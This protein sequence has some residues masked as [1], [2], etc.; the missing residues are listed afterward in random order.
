MC[1]IFRGVGYIPQN[2]ADLYERCAVM[3]FEEWDHSRGIDSGGPLRADARFA[4]QDIAYWTLTTPSLSSGIPEGLLKERLTRFLTVN[5]YGSDSMAADAAAELLLLWRGRAWILTDLGSDTLHPIYQFTHR[6][7]QEYFAATYLSRVSVSP[8]ELWRKIRKKA[9]S[10]QWDVVAQIAIQAYNTASA[11]ATDK[12]YDSI[13]RDVKNDKHDAIEELLFACQNL[14]ALAPGPRVIQQLVVVAVDLICRILPCFSRQPKWNTYERDRDLLLNGDEQDEETWK[15]LSR[16]VGSRLGQDDSDSELESGTILDVSIRRVNEPLAA[17]FSTSSLIYGLASAAFDDYCKTL[18]Q[19][20]DL[21]V[22]SRGLLL[23][24]AKRQFIQAAQYSITVTQSE[25]AL[26]SVAQKSEKAVADLDF[27]W[28]LEN[29]MR[30][31]QHNFWLLI[32]A[33]RYHGLPLR[34]LFAESGLD[35]LFNGESPFDVTIVG[36]RPC[37]AVEVLMRYINGE[38]SLDDRGLL[39]DVGCSVRQMYASSGNVPN[40]DTSWLAGP[41]LEDAVIKRYFL[42]SSD[43]RADEGYYDKYYNSVDERSIAEDY[44]REQD[45]DVILGAAIFLFILSEGE[46]WQLAD[47]SA[48]HVARL[49]LGPVQFLEG[50]LLRRYSDI[51]LLDK[52]LARRIRLPRKDMELLTVWSVGHVSFRLWESIEGLHVVG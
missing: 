29:L 2:R 3:L 23:M 19:S 16:I 46:K 45:N 26:S 50:L 22:A 4:L 40:V 18:I 17:V 35:A 37:F 48:D 14:D 31:S 12:I 28:P 7:F 21:Q 25:S 15:A 30:L 42:N 36:A 27:S 1:N 10:G 38:A 39:A 47:L 33:A 20:S 49:S 44:V 6:T 8:K 43:T 5:R 9:I 24:L 13:I 51:E 32:I 34:D 41:K 11:G 52:H